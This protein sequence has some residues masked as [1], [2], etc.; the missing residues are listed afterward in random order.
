MNIDHCPW[1]TMVVVVSMAFPMNLRRIPTKKN[2]PNGAGV[3]L[4]LLI[5]VLVAYPG[6]KQPLGA[7]GF[8]G[9][10]SHEQHRLVDACEVGVI[11]SYSILPWLTT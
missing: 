9:H 5:I 2:K 1:Q 8:R 10:L 6:I 3:G 4:F 11:F 7:D